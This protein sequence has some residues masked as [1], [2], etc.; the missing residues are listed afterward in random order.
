MLFVRKFVKLL[1]GRQ[2][3]PVGVQ[4]SLCFS[5]TQV[6][7]GAREEVKTMPYLGNPLPALNK[8]VTS[9]QLFNCSNAQ[10]N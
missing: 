1:P 10:I 5:S 2:A 8:L 7:L 6:L 4:G 9:Q 3:I